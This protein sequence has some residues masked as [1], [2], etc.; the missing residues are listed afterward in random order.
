[1]SGP[2]RRL[3]GGGRPSARG[4]CRAWHGQRRRLQRAPIQLARARDYWRHL[5]GVRIR[6]A[7]DTNDRGLRGWRDRGGPGAA[8]TRRHFTTAR[9]HFLEWRDRDAG[10]WA[11]ARAFDY[12][13]RRHD[14]LCGSLARLGRLELLEL[15]GRLAAFH[16]CADA[17]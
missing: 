12:R 1:I 7:A 6:R 3:F 13:V 4:V 14:R 10:P 16:E 17:I 11:F 15:E 9:A 2:D 5:S 8:G